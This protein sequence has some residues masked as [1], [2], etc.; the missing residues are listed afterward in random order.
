MTPAR[1]VSY[2]V[3]AGAPCCLYKKPVCVAVEVFVRQR[4]L[5]AVR[6]KAGITE[7]VSAV[8]GMDTRL[9]QRT[10]KPKDPIGREKKSLPLCPRES[11]QPAHSPDHRECTEGCYL[12]LN[13]ICA[14]MRSEGGFSS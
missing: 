1:R 11:D 4:S 7:P 2:G 14:A 12:K 6:L 8:R 13:K 3:L 5:T 9:V 10:G